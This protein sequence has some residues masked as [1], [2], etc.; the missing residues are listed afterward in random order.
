MSSVVLAD[1]LG[2]SSFLWGAHPPLN[3]I[4]FLPSPAP[5]GKEREELFS[6]LLSGEKGEEGDL[7]LFIAILRLGVDSA[8]VLS[9]S[10]YVFPTRRQQLEM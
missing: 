10:P 2:V 8:P 9:S 4:P 7:Y 5:W 1:P 3:V 6:C